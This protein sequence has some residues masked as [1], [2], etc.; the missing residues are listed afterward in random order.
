MIKKNYRHSQ[1]C[2]IN[3]WS[4]KAVHWFGENKQQMQCTFLQYFS[5]HISVMSILGIHK[6]FK[7]KFIYWKNFSLVKH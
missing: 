2:T 4:V 1:D 3:I 5:M 6:H 7:C